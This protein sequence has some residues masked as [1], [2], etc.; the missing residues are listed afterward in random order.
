MVRSEMNGV[1][2]EHRV[3]HP[4]SRDPSFYNILHYQSRPMYGL[5]MLIPSLPLPAGDIT[6]FR[7]KL[8][9]IPEIYKQAKV[10]LTE[11][12]EE[13]ALIAPEQ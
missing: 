6:E 11:G 5:P 1:E 3:I 9:A 10:N 7:T 4:W 13:L 8:K 12:S 2:L